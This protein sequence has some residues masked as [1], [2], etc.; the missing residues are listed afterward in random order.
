LLLGLLLVDSLATALLGWDAF[1]GAPQ[2]SQTYSRLE[3]ASSKGVA[4]SSA[5]RHGQRLGLAYGMSTTEQGVQLR[6]LE[7]LRPALRWAKV[8]GEHPSFNNLL[9]VA[10][11]VERE[12]VQPTRTL[13]CVHYGM[14]VGAG[15]LPSTRAALMA[16]VLSRSD[17]LNLFGEA[18]RALSLSWLGNNRQATVNA[19]ETRLGAVRE[20]WLRSWGQPSDAIYPHLADPFADV[21]NVRTARQRE[22]WQGRIELARKRGWGE[23]AAYSADSA[24][25]RALTELV[26][27][28][29][30][31]PG[32][33]VV[34][35]PERSVLRDLIPEDAASAALHGA[36]RAARVSMPPPVLDLRAALSDAD[37][38]DE[39][40]PTGPGSARLSTALNAALLSAPGAWP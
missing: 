25:G 5:Q 20:R 16:R 13:L 40:H 22:A 29:G 30:Q 32:L 21:V 11:R 3:L 14:F 10:R 6:R 1:R 12:G 9:E 15:R 8:T 38:V 28:L 34:L 19:V 26:N 4:L 18:S 2:E 33:V 23:P 37:F 36:L 7:E 17:G 24:E 27:L 31:R 39:A 35:L